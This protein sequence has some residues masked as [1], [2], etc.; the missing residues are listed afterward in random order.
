[1]A[2][3]AERICEL[4]QESA[5]AED[6]DAALRALSELR[7][8]VDAFVRVHVADA[9]LAGRSFSDVARALGISRQAAHR[10]FR[11][12]AP[13]RRADQRRP[14]VATDAA[15]R[16]MRLAQTEAAAAGASPGS[17]H[18]LLGILRTDNEATR[19]L[20]LEGVT[21][22]R[23]RAFVR[24]RSGRA[25]GCRESRSMRCILKRAARI[26]LS[27][28]DHELDVEMLLLAALADPDGGA[29][30]AVTGLAIGSVSLRT[31]LGGRMPRSPAV[32]GA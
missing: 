25:A 26:A 11:D 7:R 6:A 19:A 8:E 12:L 4:A 31:L 18:V 23:V 22:E 28:G 32:I 14:L 13:K 10:R 30:T 17:E 15:R 29:R 2:R 27:R 1:M 21:P 20:R 5:V 9:L 16:V 3:Q 24:S